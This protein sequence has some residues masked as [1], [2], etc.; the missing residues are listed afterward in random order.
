MREKLGEETY[1][2]LEVEAKR[3]A[4]HPGVAHPLVRTHPDTGREAL[5]LAGGFMRHIVGMHPLESEG[6]LPDARDP[7]ERRPLPLRWMW[8]VGDVCMW[9]ERSTN[10]RSAGDHFPQERVV[11][12]CEAGCDRPFYRP[13]AAPAA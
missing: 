12:R 2:A 8:S 13:A 7:P 9:D 4:E 3:R 10:P 11:A 1:E 6:M 5:F